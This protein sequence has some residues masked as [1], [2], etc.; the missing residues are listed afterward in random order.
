M[1]LGSICRSHGAPLFYSLWLQ[2]PSFSLI[3]GVVF[4]TRTS[5]CS[6]EEWR[7]FQSRACVCFKLLSANLTRQGQALVASSQTMKDT[8][9]VHTFVIAN[10]VPDSL[11]QPTLVQ[12]LDISVYILF[13]IAPRSSGLCRTNFLFSGC[14]QSSVCSKSLH[15][16]F[17]ILYFWS[18]RMIDYL[19]G[20]VTGGSHLLSNIFFYVSFS[21]ICCL[22]QFFVL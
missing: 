14:W 8:S 10:S 21:A 7:G 17:P 4:Y 5:S 16:L 6:G 1:G 12:F 22:I 18:C 15:I 11:A 9:S 3:A 13:G 2:S 19:L 20:H